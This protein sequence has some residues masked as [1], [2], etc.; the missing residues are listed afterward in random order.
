MSK[1]KIHIQ[2]KLRTI[3][4]SIA[5]E[6]WI[7][8]ELLHRDINEDILVDNPINYIKISGSED[9][10]ISYLPHSKIQSE[11]DNISKSNGRDLK[12]NQ[13]PMEYFY[14]AKGRVKIK[15]GSFV[16]KLFKNAPPKDV[17][18]FA[19]LVKSIMDQPDFHFKVVSGDE[20]RIYYHGSHHASSRGSLGVSCMRHDT[21]QNYFN[22][23]THSPEI[24]ML[25][26]VDLRGRILARTLLWDLDERNGLDG[27]FKFMDRI[28]ST[29][30]DQFHL[31]YEWAKKNGYTYKEKQSWNTPYRFKFKDDTFHKRMKIKLSNPPHIYAKENNGYGL[32]YLD[33]FKW[34]NVK[35][36]TLYNYKPDNEPVD[37]RR[38]IYT[39]VSTKGRLYGYNYIKEDE[40]NLEFWYEGELKFVEYLDKWISERYLSYSNINETHILSDHVMIEEHTGDN[41][42]IEEYD[43]LN[44]NDLLDEQ[45][46]MIKEK[47]RE[48]RERLEGEVRSTLI[49][50]EKF[51]EIGDRFLS[52]EISSIS[53]KIADVRV[54]KIIEDYVVIGDTEGLRDYASQQLSDID[55]TES[56]ERFRRYAEKMISKSKS[57]KAKGMG[58]KK[59]IWSSTNYSNSLNRTSHQQ[60]L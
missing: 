21:C 32:P 4:K 34:M 38:D 46:E 27:E 16:N 43:Y 42:F 60:K 39:P 11:I 55:D 44:D 33:T 29:K 48:E 2:G 47:K 51:T 3:L 8:N 17:E 56:F 14:K 26:M 12:Q 1:I 45:I 59:S 25:M 7:A 10:K 53:P 15:Y 35:D 30:D 18:K 31:F 36:G 52:D 22:M 57:M 41:I 13:I 50:F 54:K 20:I 58:G 9:N 28:Y 23:Y 40:Q 24:K 49:N 37:L 19:S 6:S 5:S